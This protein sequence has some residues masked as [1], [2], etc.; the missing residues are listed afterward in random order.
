MTE[1]CAA[2]DCERDATTEV[3]VALTKYGTTGVLARDTTE[4]CD[5]CRTALQ[6][7][8]FDRERFEDIDL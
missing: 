7:G 2:P 1:T 6:S 3:V 8:H 5:E 4:V